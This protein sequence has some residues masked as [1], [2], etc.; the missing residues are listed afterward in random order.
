MYGILIIVMM[1]VRPQGIAGASNSVLASKRLA[2][3][4]KSADGARKKEA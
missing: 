2:F 1:W 4:K 3:R